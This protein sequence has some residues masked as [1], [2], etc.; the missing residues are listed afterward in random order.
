MIQKLHITEIEQFLAESFVNNSHN[1]L[2][3]KITKSDEQGNLEIDINT[4][5]N[6]KI[7]AVGI[8][9]ELSPCEYIDFDRIDINDYKNKTTFTSSALELFD[10]FLAFN[11]SVSCLVDFKGA[12]WRV[13]IL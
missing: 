3:L 5:I 4:N 11:D 10:Y 2:T 9:F 8:D 1:P 7:E 13:M 12:A 6:R